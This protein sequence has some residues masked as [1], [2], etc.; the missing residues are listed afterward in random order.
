MT[1]VTSTII[2]LVL[3]IV[4]AVVVPPLRLRRAIPAIL[5]LFRQ[6]KATD[7]NSARTLDELGLKLKT[8]PATILG[9]GD[10]R[11][12]ALEIL[13]DAKIIQS[14]ADSKWYLS[15]S[16]LAASKWSGK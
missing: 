12:A 3:L 1:D 8:G 15:E 16:D 7:E 11:Q 14:A 13:K 2:V 6:G 10:T 9:G 4:V 5:H